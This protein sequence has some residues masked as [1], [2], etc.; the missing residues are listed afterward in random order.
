MKLS[1]LTLLLLSFVLASAALAQRPI[2]SPAPPRTSTPLQNS[3][4]ANVR[5][6][7][8]SG[9]REQ[10]LRE[11]EEILDAHPGNA[12]ASF[13]IG[14][15]LLDYGKPAEALVCFRNAQAAWPGSTDVHAGL[16]EA[17][18]ETGDRK[19]R[20]IERAILRGYHADGHHPSAAKTPGMVIERFRAGDKEIEAVEYFDPQGPDHVY[21]R[22]NVFDPGG[23]IVGWYAFAADDPD[24]AAYQNE[25]PDV[26]RTSLRR[27][28]LES[29]IGGNSA[30]LGMIDGA[31]SYDDFRS[32][33]VS[34]CAAET[35][36]ADASPPPAPAAKKNK[37]N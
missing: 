16:L 9:N 21:Y 4:F 18:A 23:V 26:A 12:E 7:L 33:I 17:F 6:D 32:R 11:A 10:A 8:L 30:N 24:Q 2:C 34:V 22:F 27:Y 31:P 29:F 15:L 35:S 19:N 20:D 3:D 1:P 13:M 5:A 14:T 36:T 28:A 37:K 25:H